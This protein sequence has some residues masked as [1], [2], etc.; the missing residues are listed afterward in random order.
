MNNKIVSMNTKEFAEFI[1]EVANKTYSFTDKINENG[2][3]E[4]WYEFI[5]TKLFQV[6]SVFINNSTFVGGNSYTIDLPDYDETIEKDVTEVQS[7][8]CVKELVIGLNKFAAKYNLVGSLWY[9]NVV[10]YYN[11][12]VEIDKNNI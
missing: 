8:E 10:D 5:N 2:E 4:I 12:N 6:Q 11:V 1:L 3:S 9:V 7:K